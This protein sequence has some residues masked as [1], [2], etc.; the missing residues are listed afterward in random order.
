LRALRTERSESLE[1]AEDNVMSEFGSAMD[2][3]F[4]GDMNASIALCGQVAGRID[5]VRPVAEVL[6]EIVEQ[7][8]ATLT[9]VAERYLRGE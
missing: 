4:G 6:T 8:E 2:L 3:Y 5:A 1:Y 7:F 9:D